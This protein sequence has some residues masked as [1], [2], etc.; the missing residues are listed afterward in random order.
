[1]APRLGGVDKAGYS[2]MRSNVARSEDGLRPRYAV[3]SALM[4]GASPTRAAGQHL[5]PTGRPGP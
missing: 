1:M 4:V 3:G 5:T 2:A